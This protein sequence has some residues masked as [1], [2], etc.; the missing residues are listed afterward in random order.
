M[1]KSNWL[2]VFILSLVAYSCDYQP[3]QQGKVLYDFHCANCHGEQGEGLRNLIPPI[4]KADYVQKNQSDLAC[5]IKNGIKGPIVVNGK[6]YDTQMVG[7]TTLND[8]QIN[9]IINYINNSWGNN[10]GDSNVLEVNKA[11]KACSQ[12]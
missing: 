7:I 3:Y 1:K 4:A 8:V 5:L 12:E 6:T 10:F 9:N 11:L 2:F